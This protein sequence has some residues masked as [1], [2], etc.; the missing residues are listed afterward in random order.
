M[1]Y[2][3]FAAFVL[4]GYLTWYFTMT[5]EG[6]IASL[7]VKQSARKMSGYETNSAD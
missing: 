5:D 3:C 4:C 7:F 6:K 1:V 2:A